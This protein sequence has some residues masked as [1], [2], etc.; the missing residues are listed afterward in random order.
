T[1]S[2]GAE[3]QNVCKKQQREARNAVRRPPYESVDKRLDLAFGLGRHGQIEQLRRRLVQ[4]ITQEVMTSPQDATRKQ[5]RSKQHAQTAPHE[6]EGEHEK[7]YPDAEGAQQRAREGQLENQG[8]E[9]H[10][11]IEA[12]KEGGEGC[13]I[14]AISS[15]GNELELVPENRGG[16]TSDR[17]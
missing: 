14:S 5:H 3:L 9:S 13:G 2:A 16:E 8:G 10:I 7:R 6:S 15:L 11:A 12:A 17:N 4:R 1:H